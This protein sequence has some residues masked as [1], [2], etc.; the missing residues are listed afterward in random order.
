L[1]EFEN[2]SIG[3]LEQ[4]KIRGSLSIDKEQARDVQEILIKI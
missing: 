3:I 2:N 4:E 1:R